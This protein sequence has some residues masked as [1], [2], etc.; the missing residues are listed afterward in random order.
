MCVCVCVCV[1]VRV[2]MYT[3]C[4]CPCKE[5]SPCRRP[6]PLHCQMIGALPSLKA[7]DCVWVVWGGVSAFNSLH[8]SQENILL[9][10]KGQSSVKV[11]DFGSSCYEHQRVYT[12][13]QSRFYR[14]PEVIL[15]E[16]VWAGPLVHRGMLSLHML[17]RDIFSCPSRKEMSYM[18]RHTVV[19]IL[20]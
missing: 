18:S 6:L 7:A 14:S 12:Y 1:C 9:K 5:P 3:V 17:K 2:C 10:L 13:I 4:V 20:H 16:L 15:G 11:I 19:Y 8:T